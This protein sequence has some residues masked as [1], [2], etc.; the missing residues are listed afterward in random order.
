VRPAA[1]TALWIL[2]LLALSAGVVAEGRTRADLERRTP[3]RPA[4]LYRTLATSQTAW[5]IVD[6]RED[7]VDGYG[8]AHVPGAIPLPGCDPEEAPAAARGRVLSSV[9]TVIVAAGAEDASAAEACAA[10]FTTARVLAGGMEAWSDAGLPEDSG[11][12]TAPSAKAGGG[13]L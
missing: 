7:L 8:D 5:Q 4:E 1:E 2:V 3:L 13:C 10:R 12:Y 9:P 6:V 11:E